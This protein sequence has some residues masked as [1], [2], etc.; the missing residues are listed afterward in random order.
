MAFDADNFVLAS[1]PVNGD[2]PAIYSYN[3][4]DAVATATAS[5]YFNAKNDLLKT[6]DLIVIN[7]SDAKAL[8]FATV[9]SGVV[10]V[11]AGS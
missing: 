4:T 7:A 9:A 3:T 11:A 5:G 2:C 8:R 1:A 10:T 6:G